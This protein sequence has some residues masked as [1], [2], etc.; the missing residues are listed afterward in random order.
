MAFIQSTTEETE[1][2]PEM[3]HT[4]QVIYHHREGVDYLNSVRLMAEV[5]VRD[6]FLKVTE[7][8]YQITPSYENSNNESMVAVDWEP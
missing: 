3:M 6:T 5:K 4:I 8:I 1:D 7:I 2:F